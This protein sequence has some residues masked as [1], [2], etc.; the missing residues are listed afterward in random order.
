LE[1]TII[2]N[3]AIITESVRPFLAEKQ[4]LNYGNQLETDFSKFNLI[5]DEKFYQE[6]QKEELK[7]VL[8]ESG[9]KLRIMRHMA[10]RTLKKNN[11]LKAAVE[12]YLNKI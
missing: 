12:N 6:F 1:S 10:E 11:E 3:N 8:F 7:Q 4:L 9:I 5:H 2:N